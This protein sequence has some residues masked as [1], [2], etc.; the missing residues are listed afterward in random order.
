[1]SVP[2]RRQIRLRDRTYGRQR[3]AVLMEAALVVPLL[4]MLL[5]GIVWFGRAYNAWQTMT[6]AARE[7][8]R[9]ASAPSCATCGNAFPTAAEVR[10]VVDS[11]L[12]A[13]S[14]DPQLV[15]GY[16]MTRNV[17][18]NPG[19]TIQE[20]GVVISFNYPF[21]FFVPFTSVHLTTVTLNAQ[22]RMREEN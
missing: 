4:L 14:L 5:I 22:V 12:T 9:F 21:Q 6:R 11:A 8:A 20:T 1:M 2:V 7:G 18:L 10:Q 13:S 16:S 3:G 17:T 15:T 19:A